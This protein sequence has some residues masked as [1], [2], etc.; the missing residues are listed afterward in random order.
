MDQFD[1]VRGVNAG[2]PQLEQAIESA[3][4]DRQYETEE[5]PPESRPHRLWQ[6]LRRL[7]GS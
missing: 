4:R 2:D 7:L 6:F 3:R 1:F 5:P